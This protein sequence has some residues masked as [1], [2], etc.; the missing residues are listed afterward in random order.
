MGN[1]LEPNELVE[2]HLLSITWQV[3]IGI[4]QQS[5]ERLVAVREENGRGST[6]GGVRV[7]RDVRASS[8][9]SKNRPRLV[10]TW[11]KYGLES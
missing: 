5:V 8:I 9:G 1:H 10:W 7:W 11:S 2:V 6:S 3:S 4:S